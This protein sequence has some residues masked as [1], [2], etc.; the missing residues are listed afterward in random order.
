MKPSSLSRKCYR[1]LHIN[2]T[3]SQSLNFRKYQP[4]TTR[5][6]FLI[7]SR[8]DKFLITRRTTNAITGPIMADP[9]QWVRPKAA[10][11]S[12]CI[13][14]LMTCAGWLLFDRAT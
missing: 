9:Q 7:S 11:T 1:F 2:P 10:P 12:V 3:H 5:T 4:A 14:T 8:M 6:D 13:D